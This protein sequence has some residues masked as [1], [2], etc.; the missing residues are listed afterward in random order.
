MFAGAINQFGGNFHH[1]GFE[2]A[3]MWRWACSAEAWPD[4]VLASPPL[5]PNPPPPPSFP[6]G[7]WG[8][9]NGEPAYVEPA[10]P[11]TH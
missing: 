11:G 9:I 7:E 8:G 4:A 3:Q 2:T 10:L 6:P 5:P 1:K